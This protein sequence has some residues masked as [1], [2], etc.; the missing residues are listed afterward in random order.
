MLSRNMN[1]PTYV[2]D[3]IPSSRR[4]LIQR[5]IKLI[6]PMYIYNDKKNFCPGDP[7]HSGLPIIEL[8]QSHADIPQL[9]GFFWTSDQSKQIA[10]PDN[11]QH[12]KKTDI[13]TLNF[14]A[15]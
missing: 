2:S 5:N 4:H 15:T 9:V 1:S 10:L 12:S 7:A 11:I 14:T 6:Y 8:S 13:H 3:K